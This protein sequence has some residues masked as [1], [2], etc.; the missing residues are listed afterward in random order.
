MPEYRDYGQLG[1]NFVPRVEVDT[2]KYSQVFLA[3]HE[4]ES[5]LPF[6]KKSFISFSFGGK[7]IEDFN[8]IA[9]SN[10]NYL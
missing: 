5:S 9:V 8:L 2:K 4:G 3:T 1:Y 6:M 7:K 10:G